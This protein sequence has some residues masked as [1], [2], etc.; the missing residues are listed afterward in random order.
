MVCLQETRTCPRWPLVLQNFTVIQGRQG[1]GMAM[2]VRSDL[3]KTVSILHLDKW[4]SG[5]RELQ[6][7]R[8]ENPDERHKSLI[9]ITAYIQPSTCTTGAIW[10]FL[11]EREDKLGDTIMICDGFNARSSL[12]DGHGIN[13]RGCALEEGLSDVL[14]TPVSTASPTW[15]SDALFTPVST[16]SPTRLGDVLFTRVST[17]SPTRLGDVLFTPVSTASPTRLGDVLFTP[18][19]TASPKRLR[20]VLFTPV[21]TAS[22]KRL[23]DVL[24]TPVSTASPKRL[25]DV[26]FTPVSTASPTRLGARQGD[27]DS[28]TDLAMVS[29]RL[30]PWTRAETIASRGSDHLPIVFGLQKPG[31][32]PR[33]NPNIRSSMV[34]QTRE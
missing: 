6:G 22:P 25:G 29:P 1:R 26:L 10:D 33:G 31:V 14:F 18:V 15:L 3:S 7:I 13:Q 30:E 12:W 4:Y 17:E 27:V 32:E 9:V 21:S 5:S 11:E 2:V 23:G 16:A 24:F 28:I 20:D 19:S 34:S 8:I